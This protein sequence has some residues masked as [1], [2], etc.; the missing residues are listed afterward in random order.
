MEYFKALFGKSLVKFRTVPLILRQI[1]I[2]WVMGCP[3]PFY[4]DSWKKNVS[5]LVGHFP[6]NIPHVSVSVREDLIGLVG[7]SFRRQSAGH[8]VEFRRR[9]PLAPLTLHPVITSGGAP[10]QTAISKNNFLPRSENTCGCN[11]PGLYAVGGRTRTHTRGFH[12]V[13]SAVST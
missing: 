8:Q 4:S 12:G 3:V 9:L 7:R 10:Q 6:Q 11:Q 2:P 5:Y 13:G 1:F